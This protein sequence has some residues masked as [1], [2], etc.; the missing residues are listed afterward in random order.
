MIKDVMARL[1]GTA[2]DEVRLAAVN[3]I[4]EIFNSHITGLFFNILPVGIA[5]EDGIGAAGAAELTEKARERGDKLELKL[6]ERLNRLQKP[7]EL[8]RFDVLGDAVAGLA[9]ERARAA[10]TFVALRPNG[11]SREPGHLIESV[12]FG[13]GRHLVLVPHRKPVKIKLDRILVAWNG[14]R[15]SAR[16]LAEALPYLS[17]AEEVTI[18][19]VDDDPLKEP[20]ARMGQDAVDHLRHHG[21]KARLHH[22]RLRD[23][24][25]G[26]TL[27]AE[28]RRLKADLMVMGGYGH[29]R[30]REWLLG[31]TTYELLHRSPV[32][33]L[34]AH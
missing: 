16:G 20:P 33:L 12:L 14:S 3:G 7:A 21:I 28:I 30:L 8:R 17:K 15:E 13:A 27:I 34:L 18:V 32:P 1:D 10:D 26:A 9:A 6:S 25:V 2:D 11:A 5:A 23:G 19:V 31:G 29:S 4:A 24:D 22:A